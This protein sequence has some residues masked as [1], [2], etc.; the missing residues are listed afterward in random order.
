L[1]T[2]GWT[3][4]ASL[5]GLGLDVDPGLTQTVSTTPPGT[6]GV[7]CWP[8]SQHGPGSEPPTQRL[9]VLD[10]DGIYVSP[11]LERDVHAVDAD[12]RILSTPRR[13]YEVPPD[14]PFERAGW[15]FGTSVEQPTDAMRFVV[16]CRQY[17]GPSWDVASDPV[18][19]G[20]PGEVV[21]VS[22]ELVWRGRKASRPVRA[23]RR[24]LWTKP[25]RW[26]GEDRP[27]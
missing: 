26:C 2:A 11:Y 16:E 23:A 8:F 3:K 19:V 12:G 15:V 7:A 24:R 13:F 14:R 4:G 1:S 22:A 20:A 25:G 17:T 10:P 18:I 5:N 6:I 27:T 9:E 21:A